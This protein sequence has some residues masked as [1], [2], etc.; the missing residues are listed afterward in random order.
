MQ[1]LRLGLIGH[2]LVD[3]DELRHRRAV[4]RLALPLRCAGRG[5]CLALLQLALGRQC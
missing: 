4:L 1:Y 2:G 5:R 3:L